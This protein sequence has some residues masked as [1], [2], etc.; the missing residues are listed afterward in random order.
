MYLTRLPFL[1][2]FLALKHI[3]NDRLYFLII[4]P[5]IKGNCPSMFAQTVTNVKLFIFKTLSFFKHRPPL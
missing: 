4:R 1:P 2:I 5:K 3:K